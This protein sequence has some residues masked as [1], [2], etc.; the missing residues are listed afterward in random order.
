[1]VISRL[2]N[3][4]KSEAN[5]DQLQKF[6]TNYTYLVNYINEHGTLGNITDIFPHW[7]KLNLDS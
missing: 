5:F 3:A 4:M 7:R 1:M 2:A 6:I